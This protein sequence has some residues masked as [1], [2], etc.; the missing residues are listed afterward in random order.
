MFEAAE[1][2]ARLVKNSAAFRFYTPI[3]VKGVRVSPGIS[4]Y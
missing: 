2:F 3:A 1:M 4:A